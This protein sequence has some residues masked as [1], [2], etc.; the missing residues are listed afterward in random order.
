[1][2]HPVQKVVVVLSCKELA[3][4]ISDMYGSYDEQY[5]KSFLH[6]T[7]WFVNYL[8][9]VA[10]THS[11]INS[12]ILASYLT[13]YTKFFNQIIEGQRVKFSPNRVL[14]TKWNAGCIMAY[15]AVWGDR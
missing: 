2:E 14:Y 5:I 11:R 6:H 10:G 3:D 8:E 12:S 7:A 9:S 13:A 1:M 4:I 15:T